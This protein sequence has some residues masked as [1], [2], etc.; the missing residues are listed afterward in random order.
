MNVSRLVGQWYD[1]NK[2][3]L[4]WRE[5][6]NPYY[7][8]LSE[9]ILQQTRV[10]QGTPCYH[11]FIQSYPEIH[12]LAAASIEDVLL[13]WQGLGYYTRARNLHKAANIIVHQFDGVFPADYEQIRKLPG[14]GDYTAAAIASLAFN[15]P[16][17]AL[18]GNVYRVLARYLGIYEA[19]NS[20]EGKKL[21]RQAALEMLDKKNPGKHNQAMIELGALIC[22]PGNPLC[23]KC[24]IQD[25]CYAKKSNAIKELP[26]KRPKGRISH[27]FFYYLLIRKSDTVFI[28]QRGEGDI[29]ALLYEFPLIESDRELDPDELMKTKNWKNFFS[30]GKIRALNFSEEYTH[31]LSHQRLHTRFVEIKYEGNLD[32][33]NSKCIPIKE[34]PDYPFPA[35]IHKFLEGGK[36]FG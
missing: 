14:I 36:A 20:N 16:Y 27:R 33:P 3:F 6:K 22:L 30:A 32:I 31:I 29:W 21:F 5:D 25:S 9:I 17:A 26:V 8:W 12:D 7:I 28:A 1:S 15:Q 23:R 2:R 13:I 18:D 11:R 19:V 35:L 4:P 24:P 10:A 34:L